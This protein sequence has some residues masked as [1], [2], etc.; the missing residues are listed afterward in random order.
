M[1]K[2]IDCRGMACPLPVVNAKKAL[3]AFSESGTLSVRVDNDI[4][5]QNLTKFGTQK[6]FKV[7]HTE[8][9]GNDFT[10]KIEADIDPSA[11]A[12]PA[13]NPASAQGGAAAPQ[14]AKTAVVIGS[15]QMGTGDEALG[16][17]LIKA[18]IFALTSQDT[19]P[20]HIIFYNRGAELSCEGSDSLDD[21][22]ALAA[23]G[24]DIM[25]CGTCLN[26]YDLQDRL[27]VGRVSNMY[28]IVETQLGCTTII[29]P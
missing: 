3:E 4:A 14:R 11:T 22:R 19:V 17:T 25:T 7:T 20:D 13:P 28:D 9:S 8:E 27:A 10:V 12:S 24:A 5:V 1:D 21:L 2:T 15:N 6:G 18:F 26:F 16:K 23:A 29:R